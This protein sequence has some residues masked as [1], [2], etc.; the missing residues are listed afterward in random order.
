MV[1]LGRFKENSLLRNA[2]HELKYGFVKELDEPLGRMLS[3]VF[4]WQL[5]PVLPSPMPYC[6]LC[7]LPLHPKRQ[8]WRGF[9]Q[10]ELLCSVVLAQARETGNENVKLIDLLERVRFERPQM[11]LLHDQRLENMKGAFRVRA[12]HTAMRPG[13]VDWPGGAGPGC[14]SG[15]EA[16]ANFYDAPVVLVDDIATTLATLNNAAKALK[17]AGFKRVYGLTLA[18]VF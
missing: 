17:N 16:L 2:I 14:R 18:R 1:A 6:I 15:N 5:A 9:N 12:A 10:T 4:L 13:D 8:R 3:E 7:P 11:E